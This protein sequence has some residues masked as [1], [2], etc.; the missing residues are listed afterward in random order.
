MNSKSYCCNDISDFCR[1]DRN[2]D[3][4]CKR[5]RRP[6]STT[7]LKC[8]TPSTVTIPILADPGST[9]PTTS[10]SL[11]TPENSNCCTRLD[12]TSN[13]VVPVGFLGTLSFQIFKQ[14]RNQLTPVPVGPAFTFARTV[15]L[16]VG[17]TSTFS[18]F[19]CDCDFACDDEC[20]T[21]SV[22][23]TNLSAITLGATISSATLSAISTCD[24][25]TCKC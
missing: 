9:F 19:I 3:D 10:L 18:F 24:E 25:K 11:K 13:I 8:S 21:Y 4:S 17:E 22:L 2:E 6:Q 14:C 20:C 15:A 23:I 1:R 12:F 16:V 7:T 5:N